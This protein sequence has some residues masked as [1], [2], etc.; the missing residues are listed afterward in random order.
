MLARAQAI[1]AREKST[2]LVEVATEGHVVQ[3]AAASK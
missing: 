1:V 3:F 2:M